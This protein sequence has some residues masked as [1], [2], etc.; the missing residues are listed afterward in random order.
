MKMLK[1]L[2]LVI[3]APLWGVPYLIVKWYRARAIIRAGRKTYPVKVVESQ[4]RDS[5]QAYPATI[6]AQTLKVP[7]RPDWDQPS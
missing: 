4:H 6:P 1:L 3:T 5:Y 7:A 2:A